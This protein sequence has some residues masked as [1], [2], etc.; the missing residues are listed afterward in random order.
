MHKRQ[1][2]ETERDAYGQQGLVV[3]TRRMIDIKPIMSNVPALEISG[4]EWIV[5]PVKKTTVFSKTF[6]ENNTAWHR[7][8]RMNIQ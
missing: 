4:N 1:R 8:N 2:Q 7:K 3:K 5:E 6:S